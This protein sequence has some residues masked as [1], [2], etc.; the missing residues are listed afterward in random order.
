[1]T[2]ASR[3]SRSPAPVAIS[4]R[5]LNRT[6]LLRQSLL[7]RATE[8]PATAI[9]RLAGLQAQHAKSPYI[10]LWSRLRDF[11]IPDL[12]KALEDRTV[13]KASAIR[14]TLHL[15]AAEDYPPFS[16]ASAV[17]RIA[18]WRP[19]ASR[20]GV[21]TAELHRRMLRSAGEPRTIAE[22]EGDLESLASDA[23]LAPFVPSGVR[24][25]AFL[26]A[27]AHGGLVHV[28]PSGTWDA[29]GK[30]SYIDA[31]VWL[32]KA[33]RPEP[34]GALRTTIERYLGAY[35][36]ASEADIGRWL[37]QPRL[38]PI[39]EAIDALGERIRRFR[40]PDD[41]E[42]VDLEGAPL[43]TGDEPAPSR[44]LA[45]WDSVILGYETRDRIL[46]PGL[47]STVIKKNAD[48]RATFTVDGFVAGTWSV[49]TSR[50][51]TTLEIKPAATVTKTAKAELTDEA[52]RLVQF[53]AR[54]ANATV[55]RW[56]YG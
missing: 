7:E 30:P 20:A 15:V 11:A 45:R 4:D 55:V 37:G 12:E 9:K 21:D 53:M 3:T 23:S 32:P 52:E 17:A 50:G 39:H 10:A 25:V 35:G 33:E 24:H 56:I 46:P 47:A 16:I 14:N 27:S 31:E 13:V 8:D 49:T 48:I 40:R 19:S 2:K 34:D 6:T 22:L 38:A 29:F 54:G 5:G 26:M 51:S 36:P 44:F 18:A 42:V 43:A 1:M 28:P 41:R